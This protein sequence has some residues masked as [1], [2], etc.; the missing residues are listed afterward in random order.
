[1]RGSARRLIAGILSGAPFN[2]RD[3]KADLQDNQAKYY[4]L[5][6]VIKG[7][8]LTADKFWKR[9]TM[10]GVTVSRAGYCPLEFKRYAM[11][12][13]RRAEEYNPALSTTAKITGMRVF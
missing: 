6:S 4:T 5:D 1:M 2:T 10:S 11:S 13:A 7:Q 9:L 3:A 12:S 8:I